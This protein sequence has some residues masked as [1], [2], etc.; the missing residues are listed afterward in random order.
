M[1]KLI[2]ILIGEYCKIEYLLIIYNVESNYFGFV[3][4]GWKYGLRRGRKC[5]GSSWWW[6][7]KSTIGIRLYDDIILC[8]MVKWWFD[9]G[10]DIARNWI[11][12]IYKLLMNWKNK[13]QK[14]INVYNLVKLA[15]VDATV[16]SKVAGTYKVQG[17]PTILF[18]HKG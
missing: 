9:E 16:D 10:V 1:S 14:V 7:S 4:D 15:K 3:T 17:Y 11:Q 2:R 6:F 12:Y 8:S 18:F 5:I 13:V